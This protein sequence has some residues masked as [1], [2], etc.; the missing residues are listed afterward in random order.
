MGLGDQLKRLERLAQGEM[1][2]IPQTDG[3]V[4]KF[5]PSDLELAYL[6]FMARMGGGDEA[7]PEH[8][9]LVAARNSTDPKWSGSFFA[10][11]G[12]VMTEPP[13]EL[14]E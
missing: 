13:E 2:T 3:T 6:N 5:P 11:T 9:L 7:P 10:T 14:F 8:P 1:I 12:D 4:K